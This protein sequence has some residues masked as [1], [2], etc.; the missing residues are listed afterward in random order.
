M[1]CGLLEKNFQFGE[2][3]KARFT[4]MMHS[5]W[6]IGSAEFNNHDFLPQFYEKESERE[7]EAWAVGAEVVVAEVG[8]VVWWV[9]KK[10]NKL[11]FE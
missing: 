11:A 4:L 9:A 3:A 8:V 10:M 2:E 6:R 5:K 1:A 7:R